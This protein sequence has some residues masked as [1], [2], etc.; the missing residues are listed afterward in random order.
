MARYESPELRKCG[1]VE[2]LTEGLGLEGG[3]IDDL[4]S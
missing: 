2:E 4:T 3:D 1:A